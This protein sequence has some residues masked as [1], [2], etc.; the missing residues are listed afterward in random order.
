MVHSPST[1]FVSG[2]SALTMKS[3]KP[4]NP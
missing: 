1:N 4:E 3:K 2:D